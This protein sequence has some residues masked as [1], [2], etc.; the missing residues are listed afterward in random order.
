VQRIADAAAADD[1]AGFGAVLDALRR[2]AGNVG[3]A[4]LCETALAL[5]RA[6]ADE[7]RQYGSDHVRRLNSEL[8]RPEASLTELLGA[9]EARRQ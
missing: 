2:C 3:G 6:G 9:P 7:L 8:A 1:P 5:R 4:R